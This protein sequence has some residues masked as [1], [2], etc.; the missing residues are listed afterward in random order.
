MLLGISGFRKNN[1]EELHVFVRLSR[2]GGA[3]ALGVVQRQ[4]SF[5][6]QVDWCH[7]EYHLRH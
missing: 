2:F 3:C 1:Q 7:A 5:D 6:R 4:I